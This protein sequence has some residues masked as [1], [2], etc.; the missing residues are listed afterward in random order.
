MKF[1]KFEILC[2]FVD[3]PI[4]LILRSK[5]PKKERLLLDISRQ[6]SIKN[7]I[8]TYLLQKREEAALAASSILPT[9]RIVE[10]PQYAGLIYPVPMRNYT[11]GILGGLLLAA[12]Y[13]FFKE[14]VY[15]TFIQSRIFR[16]LSVRQ[17][18]K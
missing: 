13:I 12:V 14:F 16:F 6:Q 3:F 4:V 7:A 15:V 10:K 17:N 9:S 2:E 1:A 18:F 8:Y 11:A 5:I